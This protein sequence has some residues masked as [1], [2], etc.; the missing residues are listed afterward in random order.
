MSFSLKGTRFQYRIIDFKPSEDP[1]R[2][3]LLLLRAF[4]TPEG[5]A[6]AV[7]AAASAAAAAE[8]AADGAGE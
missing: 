1:K 6:E 3:Q 4:E 5:S 2:P 8:A 7:K